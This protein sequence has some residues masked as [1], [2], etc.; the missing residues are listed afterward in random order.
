MKTLNTRKLPLTFQYLICI[1]FVLVVSLI[2]FS[3]KLYIGYKVVALIL[4]M[5]VSIIAMLFE[6]LPVIITAFLSALIWN[7]FFIPP[8]YTFHIDQVE[9]VL[10]FFLYFFIAF[11][12]T[13]LSFK[14]RKAEKKAREKE[15]KENILK[16]YNTLFNSL[17]HELRTPISTIIGALDTLKENKAVLSDESQSELLSV[18]SK[19]SFRLNREV[20]NL[21]NMNRLESGM[22]TLKEDWCDLS[23][24]IHSVIQKVNP[25]GNKKIEF[26]PD[27]NLPFFRLDPG[28]MEQAV[29]NLL[30]NAITHT[31]DDTLIEL[32]V[33]H[34]Q[35]LCVITISDN[36]QGFP[37]NEIP[38]VFDKFYRLPH[39]KTSGSGLGLSIVK[40]FVEAHKG[41]ITLENNKSGGAKFT[42]IIP[43]EATYINNLNHE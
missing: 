25:S 31:P 32:D 36:G 33:K 29:Y 6:I 37:E 3:I 26:N 40:G 42:I 39:N 7:F 27:V 35:D 41:K 16:L 19:A 2:A 10:F 1:G 30:H 38:R 5:T 15:E 4:L 43:T 18:I 23:E 17:S 21:L 13:A 20:D 28:I 24:L 12:N 14:I 8:L 9:D 22:L 11:I 34:D